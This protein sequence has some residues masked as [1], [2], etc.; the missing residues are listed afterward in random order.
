MSSPK[1]EITSQVKGYKIDRRRIRQAIRWI[2]RNAGIETG[3]V[4]VAIVDDETIARLHGQFLGDPA[5]TDVLS[6]L[7]EEGPAYL[8]GEVIVSAETARQQ[9][10]RLKVPEE[11]EL[12]LYI[13]HGTLHLVGFDDQTSSA[14]RKMRQ[15][16]QR[17]FEQLKLA[18]PDR[19]RSR[20]S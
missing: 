20:R 11:S 5:P 2:L 16:E 15:A 4:S 7:L 13:V 12:L 1:I 8:E 19:H 6:F 10:G 17:V 18:Y 9:S 3:T 14:R